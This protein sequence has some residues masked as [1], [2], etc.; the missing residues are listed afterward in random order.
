MH[1][2]C[3]ALRAFSRTSAKCIIFFI[4]KKYMQDAKQT[5]QTQTQKPQQQPHNNQADLVRVLFLYGA[6]M[7]LIA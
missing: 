3:I 5:T 4:Y 2:P 1:A 7:L 6:A